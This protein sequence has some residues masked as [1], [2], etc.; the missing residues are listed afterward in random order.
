MAV[1]AAPS[2]K[3][4]PGRLRFGAATRALT[5]MFPVAARDPGQSKTAFRCFGVAGAEVE[6][7]DAGWVDKWARPVTTKGRS[8][9]SRRRDAERIPR[10]ITSEGRLT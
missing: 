7:G 6:E 3:A 8:E 10:Q 9:V 5:T 1:D 2:G 4:P